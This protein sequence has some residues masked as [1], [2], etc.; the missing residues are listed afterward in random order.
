MRRWTIAVCLVI[1]ALVRAQDVRVVDDQRAE[2]IGILFRIAGASDFTNGTVQPYISQVDSAFLPF[3]RHPVFNDINRL[4]ATSGLALSAV[5]SLAPQLT[6][7]V[8]FRERAPIDAPSSTLA[9]E[10]VEG[11]PPR[12][13]TMRSR[14]KMGAI[15]GAVPS[16]SC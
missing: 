3:K 7:P 4:R 2:V 8:S 9:P 16:S 11:R 6:D 10:W 13:P 15:L 14:G 1:P 5:I 12:L